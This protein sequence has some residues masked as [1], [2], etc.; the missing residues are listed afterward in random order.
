MNNILCVKDKNVSS[1]L[2]GWKNTFNLLGYKFTFWN[3]NRKPIFDAFDETKPDILI[4]SPDSISRGLVSCLKEN[5]T[6]KGILIIGRP[7]DI[8]REDISLIMSL[9]I[10]TDRPNLVVKIFTDLIENFELKTITSLPAADTT[11]FYPRTFQKNWSSDLTFIGEYTEE[12]ANYILPLCESD[13]P[14]SIRI[15]G[16]AENETEWPVPNYVGKIREENIPNIYSSSKIVIDLSNGIDQFNIWAC[17]G[18][19]LTNDKTHLLDT[20]YFYDPESLWK[21]VEY[22]MT[23]PQDRKNISENLQLEVIKGHT[24]QDRIKEILNE[25]IGT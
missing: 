6:I 5:P 24:Y 17:Q 19:C 20:V 23:R 10:D 9:I 14:H 11:I 12:N 1:V 8:S 18:F 15:F 22:Y 3:P 25:I 7:Q 2:N 4:F 13:Y 21:L 16:R